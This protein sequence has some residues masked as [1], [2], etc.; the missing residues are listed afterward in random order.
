[1][2]NL[3]SFLNPV[4]EENLKFVPSKRFKDDEGNYIYWEI[5]SINSDEDEKIRRSCTKISKNSASQELDFNKY[6]GLLAAACTVFPNLNDTELQDS[7]KV[8]GSDAL[9]KTMLKP[10]EYAYY[11][12]KVQEINGFDVSMNELVNTAKN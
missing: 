10:G 12:K 1:M 5:K 3:N 8:M 2:Q 6:I 4:K 11:I 9:L 7:Y